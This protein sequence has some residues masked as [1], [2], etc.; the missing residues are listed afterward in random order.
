[1]KTTL[2]SFI[3]VL[4]V[5]M[6]CLPATAFAKPHHK[7]KRH[8]APPHAVQQCGMSSSQFST[9]V[10]LVKN[11][12]FRSQKMELIKAAAATNSF[13]VAQIIQTMNLM[14]FN[15]DKVEI[16]AAMYNNVCDY[17]NWYMVYSVFDFNM[18]VTDLKR[19]I[20]VQ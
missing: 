13:T 2:K 10:A 8:H 18:Y 3:L 16:A 19:R 20:G 17:S 7:N 15:S 5:M 14:T 1:M 12:T 4:V 11:T 6:F 9:F